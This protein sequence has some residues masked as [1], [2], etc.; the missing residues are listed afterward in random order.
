MLDALAYLNMLGVVHRDVKAENILW[1]RS[2]VDD[3][4]CECTGGDRVVLRSL[5]RRG[6][7]SSK[8]GLK[9]R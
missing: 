5:V 7:D 9:I 3:V 4:K 6:T 1:V 2:N 8:I